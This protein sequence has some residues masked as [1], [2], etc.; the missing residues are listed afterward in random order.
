MGFPKAGRVL[1]STSADRIMP[2]RGHPQAVGRHRSIQ[3]LRPCLQYPIDMASMHQMNLSADCSACL[4]HESKGESRSRAAHL[5][6]VG[7]GILVGALRLAGE[8]TVFQ[9]HTP[10]HD[11]HSTARQREVSG[12]VPEV[13]C[14]P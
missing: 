6:G 8:A 9:G 11:G 2:S 14:A 12:E 3:T 7:Q 10:Q 13:G 1:R 5:I 4:H